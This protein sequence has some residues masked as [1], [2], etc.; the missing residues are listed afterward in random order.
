MVVG[1]VTF[2]DAQVP[3]GSEEIDQRLDSPLE[4]RVALRQ[5]NFERPDGADRK[6][7]AG[8]QQSPNDGCRGDVVALSDLLDDGKFD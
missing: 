1:C 3:R 8:L 2:T 4:T 5:V 7:V 6:L